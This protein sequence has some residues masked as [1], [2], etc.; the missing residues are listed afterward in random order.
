MEGEAGPALAP[1]VPWQPAQVLASML[2]PAPIIKGFSSAAK[3][4]AEALRASVPIRAFCSFVYA[5]LPPLELKQAYIEMAGHCIHPPWLAEQ[6]NG[7]FLL[8][9][10]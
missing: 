6:L 3:A 10:P 7:L 8:H 9:S 4:A 1:L 5:M 2:A